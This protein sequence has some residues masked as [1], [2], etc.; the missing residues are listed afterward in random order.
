MV[1]L[2]FAMV[3]VPAYQQFTPGRIDHH[4]V[5]IA[6]TLLAVAA[7]AWSDRKWW[8][9]YAAGA[10]S[11]VLLA[12]GIEC[13]PYLAACGLAL[14][15]RY[16]MDRD[17]GV[18]LARYGLALALFAALAFGVS[19]GPQHWTRKL[20][21]A[22]AIN[23]A[24]AAVCG[25]LLLALAGR[26]RHR[27][28]ITRI[29]AVLGSAAGTLAVLLLIEPRCLRGPMAMVDPAIWP[30]WLGDVR[31]MQPL[32]SV[33]RKN[34][35]TASAIAAFPVAAL[36]AVAILLRQ[37]SLRR[38]FGFLTAVLVFFAAAA[39][40]A[41]AI[42]GF[43]YA[44]WLGMPVVAMLA[45]RLIVAFQIKRLVPRLAIA[46]V[47]TPMAL[48]AA[49]ISIGTATG[50]S[51][52]DNFSRPDMRACF[53]TASYAP[54]RD[55]EPGLIAADVSFGPYLLA[56]TP[57]SALAAPY[58]RLSSGI[59]TAHRLLAAPPGRH[60][61]SRWTPRL[62]T[63]RSA[64][65]VRRTA[66]RSRREA[67]ACGPVCRPGPRPTGSS[68]W[69]PVRLSRCIA[70]SGPETLCKSLQGKGPLLYEPGRRRGLRRV[71]IWGS[72][73]A[74]RVSRE[75]LHPGAARAR[76]AC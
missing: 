57:H 55:L 64:G 37:E 1:A 21:D 24:A 16:V 18:A 50:L 42:R 59:V 47:L 71:Q 44:I 8:C 4:N 26:L 2:L 15:L 73:E 45:L 7:T 63:S 62:T 75:R 40:T 51:D 14:A 68:R 17:A 32:L 11:G 12:I 48:S 53:A 10:L 27:D 20:C 30:I 69:K 58:H 5:Q 31:E 54:L 66:C 38:D 74:A 70:W 34:P 52:R 23:T 35:L 76:P 13:L 36:V 72:E 9:G 43:S 28:R 3:G 25:G 60:A 49:A 46:L 65:R 67:R 19:V 6:L 61:I 22:I 56:L 29:A 41:V 33:F 39:T